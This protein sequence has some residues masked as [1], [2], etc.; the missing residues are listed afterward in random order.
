MATPAQVMGGSIISPSDETSEQNIRLPGNFLLGTSDIARRRIEWHKTIVPEYEGCYAVILDN[1]FTPTECDILRKAAELTAGSKW[2]QAMVNVGYGEQ[3]L[4]TETRDC[5]RIIWDEKDV[6][7]RIWNRVKDCV[8]EIQYLIGMPHVTGKGPAKRKEIWKATGLNERMRFLKYG[9]GQYFR[10]K[11]SAAVFFIALKSNPTQPTK[12]AAMRPLT[13]QN[14]HI[15]H[16]ISISAKTLKA[17]RHLSTPG[18]I[19]GMRSN[20]ELSA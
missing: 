10:G 20:E 7:V 13:A 15:S 9:P 14:A 1:A 18:K 5:G 17:A 2:E 19:L 16:F 4:M 12:M 3:A 11:P 8:P 6:A